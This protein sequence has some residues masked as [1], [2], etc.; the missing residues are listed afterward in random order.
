MSLRFLALMV[1][2]P[3]GL[4]SAPAFARNYDCSK[5]GNANKAA[6]KGA[7]TAPAPA[8]AATAKPAAPA[9]TAAK[10]AQPAGTAAR[11]YDCSKPGN[12]NKAVCKGAVAVAPAPAAAPVHA[13]APFR[14]APAPRVAPTSVAPAPVAPAHAGGPTAGSAGATGQCKDGT[15]T[16]ATQHRGACSRHGGVA[17]WF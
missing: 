13:P 15:Y 10:T 11:H 4:C 14:P 6:C 3:I 12:A 7:A 9:A 8:K 1:I 2:L 16:H 5:A 17:N